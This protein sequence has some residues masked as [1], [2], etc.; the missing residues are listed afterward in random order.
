MS[1]S[2]ALALVRDGERVYS[3]SRPCVLSGERN[4]KQRLKILNYRERE[5][6]YCGLALSSA[7]DTV[8]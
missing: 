7:G 3:P 6:N 1:C 2:L 8:A 5:G 4:E